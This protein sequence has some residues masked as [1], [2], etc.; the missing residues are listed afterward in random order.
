MSDWA[1]VLEVWT[2]TYYIAEAHS[3]G[4]ENAQKYAFR[5]QKMEKKF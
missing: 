5:D 3:D 2:W 4:P 1:G